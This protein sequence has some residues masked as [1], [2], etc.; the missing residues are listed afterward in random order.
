MIPLPT[1]PGGFGVVLA[2]PAYDFET[3]SGRGQ[4]KSPSRHYST[5]TVKRICRLPVPDIAAKD[6]V[7]FL[8]IPFPHIFRA[9]EIID[10]WGF[11]YSGLGWVWLKF[12][13]ITNKSPIGCG[14]GGTRKNVEPCLL[15]RRGQ[16]KAL[17]SSTRDWL[18]F[19]LSDSPD[20]PTVIVAPRRQHSRK[21]DEQYGLIERLF[22]GPYVELFARIR[23]PG[24]D[25][26][27]DELDR[28]PSQQ[29]VLDL[30]VRA[31]SERTSL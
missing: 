26:W 5:M 31:P 11:R 7:L 28:V 2:D 9:R 27:G 10:Y 20:L 23:R 13:P 3:W 1:T 4:G 18:D 8:W 24:W 30:S 25:A 6:S 19:Y 15:A 22:P 29:G 14:L 16:P 17:N 12:N 21:P